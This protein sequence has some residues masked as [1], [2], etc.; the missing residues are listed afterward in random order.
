M[1]HTDTFYTALTGGF[2]ISVAYLF[3]GV[4]RLLISL[5]IISCCDILTGFLVG[6]KTTGL[7]SN[8]A[9][10]GLKKKAGML[11]MIIVAVQCDKIL[12]NNGH[13]ARIAMLTWLIG[14]EGISFF[15]NVGKLGMRAPKW[16]LNI[17]EVLKDKGEND[18]VK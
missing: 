9:Y 8:T 2:F 12:G 1:K 16:F 17:F 10:I 7:N 14:V 15:E 4:D 11:M 6:G 13:Y 5:L 18:N 3:G